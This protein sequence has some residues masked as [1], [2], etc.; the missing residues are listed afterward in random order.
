[1]PLFAYRAL[2][3][4]GNKLSGIVEA[5][6]E[7]FAKQQ[8]RSQGLMVTFITSKMKNS[9][10]QN[11]KGQNRIAFTV[12]LAQL[13]DAGV[14]LY[15]CLV[16]IEEQ[17]RREP[18]HRVLVSL[19]E[20]IQSG[21]SLSQAMKNF[22]NTFDNL[23]CS[24][25]ASG[26]AVGTLGKSL[27]KIATLLAKQR[28]LNK[29]IGNALIYP[30]ILASF[31]LLV[32]FLL[33]GFVVPS[34][35]GIFA[36]RAV[37]GMTKWILALSH[38]F[39]SYGVIALPTIAITI[40][41]LVRKLRSHKGR[42]WIQRTSLKIPIIRH[43]VVQSAITR[44]TRTMATLQQGGLPL[45]DSLRIARDVTQNAPIEEDLLRAEQQIING[46]RLSQE[47]N[48]SSYIPPLVSRMV[49]VGEESGNTTHV[50]H[51][52]A[53]MYEEEL[54]KSIEQCMALIQPIILLIMGL[55]IGAVLIAILLP[56]TDVGSFGL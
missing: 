31:A 21:A 51:K 2:D 4:K 39:R 53:D 25:V 8:L 44:F 36:D 54:E 32:I 50:F 3:K 9:S 30:A 10:K 56:L 17:S 13:L 33:L 28:K 42:L 18:Y 55:L 40:V 35:E 34:I 26:E 1:M 5:I 49:A 38:G 22:P 6:S 20:Q 46:K 14:P 45:I 11:L 12:Q 15:E 48:R 43:L 7:T 41:F 52:I 27:E 23:Y 29:Q 24:L 16:A 47:L 19:T 37:S